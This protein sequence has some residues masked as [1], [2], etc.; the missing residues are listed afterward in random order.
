[1]I[2]NVAGSCAS[3]PRAFVAP[4]RITDTRRLPIAHTESAT[5]WGDQQRRIL[6]EA[7]YLRA[8]RL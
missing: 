4:R 6:L 8:L 2:N 3:L 7:A 1:M 5:G